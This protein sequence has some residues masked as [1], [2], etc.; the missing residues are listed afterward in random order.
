MKYET[1]QEIIIRWKGCKDKGILFIN[2]EKKR[3]FCSYCEIYEGALLC[4]GALQEQGM[5]ENDK[6]IFQFDDNKKF[7]FLFWACILGKIIPIPLTT[8]K[9][10]EY[11][12]KMYRI[13]KILEKSY[14]ISEKTTYDQFF[15]VARKKYNFF[16]EMK[17]NIKFI[18]YEELSMKKA[19]IQKCKPEDIAFI[20]FTSGSTGSPKGVVL[21][22]RNLVANIEAILEKIKVTKED[23]SLSWMPLSHDMGL[24]G[25]HVSPFA[26]GINQYLMPTSTFILNP[27][28]WI[29]SVSEYKVSIL[30]SPNFGY[31]YYLKAFRRKKEQQELDLRNVRV[32][33]NGAEPISIDVCNDFLN[34]MSIYGV[35]K[36]AMFTVYGLAEA[37][38]AVAFPDVEHEIESVT[39]D[40]RYLG[41]G[42]KVVYCNDSAGVKCV[43][44]GEAVKYCEI[45]IKDESGAYIEEDIVGYICI[46]GK[47][48]TEEFFNDRE[49]TNEIID[50]NGWL[51]T[52]DLGF[53]HDNKLI[54]TGRAK[55]VIFS[56][57]VNIYSSDLEN[58]ISTIK[59]IPINKVAVC[60]C[61]RDNSADDEIV[62]FI[63][64]KWDKD[65]LLEKTDQIKTLLWGK[66]GIKVNK[67]IL[68]K[69]IP[70]TTS[71]KIQHYKLVEQ[72]L[73]HDF[74]EQIRE[75]S[76]YIE[77]RKH[78]N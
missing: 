12:D 52:Y 5:K 74:D 41:I 3:E 15:S 61:P 23:S 59:E 10:E 72:Y 49:C 24:I 38:L 63:A 36:N 25:F 78:V 58:I 11:L 17:K 18:N 26:M 77:E 66:M 35:R 31:I 33:F 20:Q 42:D 45:A 67:I 56:N 51:N 28:L 27:L 75:I 34:E 47:N 29:K 39:V 54:V 53:M 50:E 71:G 6:I 9:T 73:N 46:K 19:E 60:A 4:L 30:S 68:V 2:S 64:R 7:V 16:R 62:V 48:V 21:K 32:I 13:G 8:V 37:C 22:H 14:V 43:I 70:K 76:Q 40:R 69:V 57:G 55:D 1:L 65:V 44:E